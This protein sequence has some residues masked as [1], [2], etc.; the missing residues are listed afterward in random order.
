M[1]VVLREEKSS[2]A[3]LESALQA[4]IESERLENNASW[5][6]A[7]SHFSKQLW[8]R[9]LHDWIRRFNSIAFSGTNTGYAER[10]CASRLVTDFAM[11][12]AW[13][14]D[15][16]EFAI[17]KENLGKWMHECHAKK[18]ALAGRFQTE[19]AFLIWNIRN[20]DRSESGWQEEN[21]AIE[22][23]RCIIRLKEL[24]VDV[25][26]FQSFEKDALMAIQSHLE[27]TLSEFVIK[28]KDVSDDWLVVI[29]LTKI[30][31]MLAE[32]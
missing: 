32:L 13:N 10:T 15:P 2:P 30:R 18:R 27:Q 26:E 1:V 31:S 16:A 7:L 12:A 4:F 11:Y 5:I 6:H 20:L 22:S 29:R 21:D 8:E 14:Q 23:A 17:T 3:L 19:A 24:G 25:A 9:G 28:Y